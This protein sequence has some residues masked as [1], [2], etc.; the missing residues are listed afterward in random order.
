MHGL[1]RA[2]VILCASFQQLKQQRANQ[3]KITLVS[4]RTQLYAEFLP[5]HASLTG[6]LCIV[7]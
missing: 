7:H 6:H 3:K 5:F 1:V 2:A 4:K